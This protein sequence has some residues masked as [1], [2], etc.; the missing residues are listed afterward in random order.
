MSSRFSEKQA[1]L[2]QYKPSRDEFFA[3]LFQIVKDIQG[4]EGNWA[5]IISMDDDTEGMITLRRSDILARLQRSALYFRVKDVYNRR[6]YPA[7]LWSAFE[8]RFGFD[9][10]AVMSPYTLDSIGQ[11]AARGDLGAGPRMVTQA[12]ALAVKS[13]EKTGQVYTPLQFVDDFLTGLVLF[14]QQGKFPTAVKKALDN[15]LVRSSGTNK[16]VI[17]LLAAY[18]MG[19][20]EKVL[21]EFDLLE[22][23]QAFPS[24][25]RKELIMQLAGGPTLYYLAEE[26][27]V[28]ENIAQR[29][30][31]EF[32]SRFAP[33]KTYASRAA[34]GLLSQVLI[35]PTF[36][37]WKSEKPREIDVNGTN[38]LAVRLQGSFESSYPERV[39]SVM[40]AAVSHSPLPVWKKNSD[41]ADI[42][43]RFELNFSML[44]TEP[45]RLIVSP[46]YPNIAIF[47]LNAMAINPD[48]ASK[49][50]PNFLFEYYTSETWNP[51]LTLSL[52]DHLFKNRGDLPEEQ[53]RINAVIQPLRQ[54][55][56]LVLLGD[57]LETISP[58]FESRMVGL[59]CIKDLVKKQC[60]QLYPGYRTLI[61]SPKWQNNLQQY[62]H[63]LQR[64]MSQGELSLARG[65]R[66]WKAT[67]EEVADAFAIPGRRLTNIEPLLDSLKDLIVKEEFSGRTASSKVTLRFH[68]HPLE[69]EWLKQLDN[70]QETVKRDGL[71]I[72]SMPAELL[73]RQAEKEGYTYPERM[74]VLRLLKERG[75]IDL[76]QKRN[77]LTRTVDA[78]DDLRDAVQEQL[79]NLEAQIRALT[80]ALPDFDASPFPLGKLHS[81]L[82]EA[83]ER[84]QIETVKASL[85]EHSSTINSLAATRTTR[86]RE[87][88]RD[89]QDSLHKL[90][91]EGIPPWLKSA[92]DQSPLADLLEKQ[93][94]DL[95]SEYQALL[96]EIS[97]VHQS[98]LSTT[99]SI[100]GSSI[101]IL[102]ST[103]EALRELTKQ[104]QK[105]ITRL[106][107]DQDRQEDFEAWR[108]VSKAAGEL[109]SEAYK[110][111][112]VYNHAEFKTAVDQLWVALH[113]RFEAQPLTFLGSYKTVSKE[114][115]AHRQ[116]IIQWLESR[117]EEFDFQRQSYQ[118][119]LASAGIQTELRIPFDRERP[120]ESQAAVIALVKDCLDRHFSS[121]YSNLKSSEQI[122]RYSIQVQSLELSNAEA[123]TH[124]A[125]KL[126]TRLRE[127]IRIEVISDQQSFEHS[128]LK[129]LVD[130]TEEEKKLG[131]EVQQAI[132]QRPAA[133]SE[134]KLMKLLQPSGFGQEVDLREL[135]MRLIDQ[136]EG[137]VD[138]STLMHDLESLFQKNLVDIHIKLS[139]DER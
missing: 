121:L 131:E 53:N 26:I 13:Y 84:D 118:Q 10:K 88:I 19:C 82:T 12:L 124:K 102:I 109:T 86:L 43:L 33:G 72:P 100:Q 94:R 23:F 103:Y 47:Q 63:A 130:L 31:N 58:E 139:G 22:A 49:I 69:E 79:K 78:V 1:T 34:D 46:D 108:R 132:Q 51:L 40:V 25:A 133:G 30:T 116:R 83:K 101:E 8:Q 65:R 32:A 56:L 74:E 77:L 24:L 105:L 99:H 75:F 66:S 114:V 120:A 119:L 18:P 85:R 42:E 7:E 96:E 98:S 138:L 134:L 15:D 57:Q 67:K 3:H 55:T 2:A 104:S 45:S 35:S 110:A 37:G 135:I 93:R 113:A 59:D 36:V 117:R 54:Y 106:K 52:I 27:V 68:L 122:I 70:S 4:L 137:T 127:Q 21:A 123:R 38:Y 95:A 87:N 125:L 5:L 16:H 115:E 128:I 9:G 61:T 14:D 111:H 44:S 60:Q 126:A 80:D 107:S 39:V 48:E 91:K 71:D 62:T 29:L 81:E 76:D 64:F 73:L 17:K 129:P 50:L 20:S 28:I 136:R 112:Q 6:E 90:L 89:A 41:E 92:F 97:Q 11:V